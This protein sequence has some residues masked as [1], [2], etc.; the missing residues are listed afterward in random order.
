MD[1]KT[2]VTTD[3]DY[4]NSADEAHFFVSKGQVKPLPEILTPLIEDA[5]AQQLLREA[6]PDEIAEYHEVQEIMEAI[7]SRKIAPGH[8]WKETKV[9]FKTYKST[10]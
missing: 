10:Q 3:N 5:L 7:Q 8:D 6:T 2:Y 4:W 1:N 9:N